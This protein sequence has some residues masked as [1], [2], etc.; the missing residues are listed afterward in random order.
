MIFDFQPVICVNLNKSHYEEKQ[1]NWKKMNFASANSALLSQFDAEKDWSNGVPLFCSIGE[2]PMET[3]RMP[4]WNAHCHTK[5]IVAC[6]CILLLFISQRRQRA[7]QRG[8][9]TE[10]V[11][12][13]T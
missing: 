1:R 10:L 5:G 12:R 11:R 13:H 2:S 9:R 7:I 4:F 8:L 3:V 6:H